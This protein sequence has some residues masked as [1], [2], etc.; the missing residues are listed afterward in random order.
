MNN[1]IHTQNLI[2]NYTRRL[3]KLKEHQALEGWSVNPNITL[4]IEDIQRHLTQLTQLTQKP[5]PNK[6][7]TTTIIIILKG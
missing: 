6:P 2:T 7:T 4:E 1:Q 5:K 3:H